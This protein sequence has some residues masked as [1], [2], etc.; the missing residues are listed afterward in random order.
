MNSL[1]SDEWGDFRWIQW[2]E[3]IQWFQ[4]NSVILAEFSE[5]TEFSG[6]WWHQLNSVTRW[7]RWL[8]LNS[9]TSVKYSDI[10]WVHWLHASVKVSDFRWILLIRLNSVTLVIFIDFDISLICLKPVEFHRFHLLYLQV[11]VPHLSA[12][13]RSL[14]LLH[15]CRDLSPKPRS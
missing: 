1:T 4:M 10:S 3:K 13:R 9:M 12:C 7:I 8:Q 14:H 15:L 5:F 2:F 11:R 6:K